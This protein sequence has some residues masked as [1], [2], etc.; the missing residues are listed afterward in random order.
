MNKF[1]IEEEYV[2]ERV[3]KALSTRLSISRESIQFFLKNGDILVNNKI[4]KPSYK[5]EANDEI[6]WSEVKK[7]D[8]STLKGDKT[9]DL[10]VVY[11]DDDILVVNKPKGLVV[12]PGIANHEGTLANALKG[13]YEDELSSINGDTRPG[14]VHRIDKDTS[15][16]LVVAK[17]DKAH[18]YLSSLLKDHNI[19][20][21]Y[22]ALVKGEISENK[23][24][25]I[26]PI[27]RDKNSPTK[28]AVNLIKGK[29]A[30]TH[31]EVLTRYKGYTLIKCNLETGRTHQIRVHLTYIGYPIVGDNQYGKQ[32]LDLYS[33]GQLLHA[34]ELEF[35]H[36]V[37]KEV[38]HFSAPLPDYFLEVLDKLNL[39]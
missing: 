12:H 16:L 17:N 21:T 25:I 37:T 5:L 13:R 34:S 3:D 38:M 6:T 33:D 31:F 18:E 36:P 1:I 27:G 22:I 39:K 4:V 9:I 11:E 23:A 7:Q 20:R 28:M 30:I 14:I 24:K 15:G 10:N 35:T 19:K 26:A 2:N 8:S 29:E 32:N